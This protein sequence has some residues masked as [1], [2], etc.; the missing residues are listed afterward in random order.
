MK[1]IKAG[2]SSLFLTVVHNQLAHNNLH[3]N[4]SINATKSIL[5]RAAREFCEVFFEVY[6]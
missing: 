4:L 5:S 3:D 2:F 6:H 1:K